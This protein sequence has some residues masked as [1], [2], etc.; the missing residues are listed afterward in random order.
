MLLDNPHTL[1]W[2][3]TIILNGV[4][5]TRSQFLIRAP[6]LWTT[7]RKFS[8]S[9]RKKAKARE[10]QRALHKFCKCITTWDHDIFQRN[11]DQDEQVLK[12]TRAGADPR[13]RNLEGNDVDVTGDLSSCGLRCVTT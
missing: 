1:D 7:Q 8:Q 6:T 12:H 3:I 10:K 2:E 5:K 4:T 11:R 13:Q 9:K